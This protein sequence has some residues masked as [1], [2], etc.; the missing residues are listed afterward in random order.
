MLQI[1]TKFVRVKAGAEGR[2]D[3]TTIDTVRNGISCSLQWL[4]GGGGCCWVRHA[5]ECNTPASLS[6]NVSA[7]MR[8]QLV[9]SEFMI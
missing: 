8:R 1:E 5:N 6:T 4:W 2:S 3:E 7:V 9:T